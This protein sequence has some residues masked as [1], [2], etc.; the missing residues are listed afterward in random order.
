[1][2]LSHY[3]KVYPCDQKPGHVI[4]F[5]TRKASIVRLKE[6]IFQAIEKGG[7][8]PKTEVLLLKLRMIVPDRDEEQ[9]AMLEYFENLHK[10]DTAVDFTVILNLDCN[11]ACTYC[12]EG[13]LK[14]KHYMS[15]ETALDMLTFMKDRFE[16][17][18]KSISIDFHGGEPLLSADLIKRVSSEMKS[19]AESRGATFQFNLISNGSL[20][21]RKLAEELVPLGLDRIKITL[22]GPAEIHNQ[23]RPFKSGAKSF[24]ILMENIKATCDLVKIGIGGNYTPE[25]Y[26]KFITLLDLLEAEGLTPDKIPVAKQPGNSSSGCVS[27]NEAWISQADDILREEILK[28]GYHTPKPEPIHCM[29]EIPDSYVVNFNGMLYKCPALVGHEAFSVG[30]IRT[31]VED[32]AVSHRLGM[33][34]N[35]TCIACEYLPLCFGGCRYMSFVNHGDIDELDCRKPFFGTSLERMVKQDIRYRTKAA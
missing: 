5:S 31:G 13:D 8:S 26:E 14:G 10:L 25:N 34:K 29:V 16:D 2:Q 28:R 6:K 19:F 35:E 20:F 1:M 17:G 7:L 9:Q 22:D 23:S 18:K 33:W 11:F 27:V 3:L 15:D 32:Y 4:L 21:K 24:D 12:Y 30:H